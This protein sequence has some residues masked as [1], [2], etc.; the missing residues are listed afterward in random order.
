M[1]RSDD[2]GTLAAER[3][4]LGEIELPGAHGLHDAEENPERPHRALAPDPASH[5]CRKDEEQ[6]ERDESPDEREAHEENRAQRDEKGAPGRACHGRD[7]LRSSPKSWTS[8]RC[9]D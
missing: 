4:E 9:D 6:G 3:V 5:P 2:E 7:H 8:T 1:V